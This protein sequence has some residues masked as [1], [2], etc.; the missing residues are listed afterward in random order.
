MSA[1]MRQRIVVA[2]GTPILGV[3]VGEDYLD[4]A[5]LTAN[6]ARLSYHRVPLHE[7]ASPVADS[8]A[9]CIAEAVGCDLRGGVAFVDSPRTPRDVDC[10]SGTMI[11]RIDAPRAR[12]IDASLRE[13][14]RARF[15]GTMRPLS[16]FPTPLASYFA[17]CAA[18]RGC[19]PHL[20]AIA[21]DVLATVI[22]IPPPTNTGSI[23]GGTFTRFMLVGFAVFPA[24]EQLGVRAFEAYPDLQFRL[25]SDGVTLPSKKFRTAALRVRKDICKELAASLQ[26]ANFDA[27]KTLDEADA[28]VLALSAAASASAHTL[29]ELHCAPEGRFA[30][31][32]ASR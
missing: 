32:F 6:R 30:V 12:V 18:R 1:C 11:R 13:L 31:A 16:M 20:G 27:P 8:I 24:L 14:L 3:D 10:S 15:N 23:P 29:I 2:R 26:I 19:K 17:G 4:L 28:A 21:E 5:M 22:G 25:W 7:I 9:H